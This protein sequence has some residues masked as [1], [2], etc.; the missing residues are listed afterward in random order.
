MAA[1]G[2]APHARAIEPQL[3]MRMLASE[4]PEAA[5]GD[6]EA[7]SRLPSTPLLPSRNSGTYVPASGSVSTSGLPQT[8]YAEASRPARG[9]PRAA[10]PFESALAAGEQAV[11]MTVSHEE[12]LPEEQLASS[13]TM[14]EVPAE[15]PEMWIDPSMQQPSMQRPQKGFLQ[16]ATISGAWMPGNRLD[17]MGM[18]TFTMQ[19]MLAMPGSTPESAYLLVPHYTAHYL[20]GPEITDMP[21]RLFETWLEARWVKKWGDQLTTDVA[22]APGVYSDFETGQSD[23]L[24]VTG[25]V[26]GLYQWTPST[27]LVAGVLWLDRENI[28]VLPIG[29]VIFTPNDDT[30]MELVFPRPKIARRVLFDGDVEYWLHV[31]GEYGGNSYAI[32]RAAGFDD[33]VTYTDIR[34]IVGVER[35]VLGGISAMLELA[36]VFD[37]EIEYAVTSVDIDVDDTLMVR[38][39]LNY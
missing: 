27:G 35:K 36:Y 6:L 8:N 22:F 19:A 30:R 10:M 7:S 20:S 5:P 4:A 16:A 3:P 2:I 23:A 13:T 34:A 9:A 31:A 37:R 29:G 11:H 21:A 32:E 28:K 33:M 26:A 38:A 1:V 14:L 25:R 12:E 39:Q 24:R 15:G 17:E 18:S